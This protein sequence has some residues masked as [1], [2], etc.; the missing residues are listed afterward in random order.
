MCSHPDVATFSYVDI[1]SQMRSWV[2]IAVLA[3]LC[4][5]AYGNPDV[6]DTIAAETHTGA[7]YDPGEHHNAP[8]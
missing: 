4:V 3:Y 1:A 2:D 5:V 7:H 6:E 8:A